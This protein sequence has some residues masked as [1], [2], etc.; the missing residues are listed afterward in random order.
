[1][2]EVM[3]ILVYEYWAVL[4]QFYMKLLDNTIMLSKE[5]KYHH[6]GQYWYPRNVPVINNT[7]TFWHLGPRAGTWVE[8]QNCP[9]F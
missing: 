9:S 1:M 4:D 5:R 8:F 2:P 6:F 7:K 3:Q